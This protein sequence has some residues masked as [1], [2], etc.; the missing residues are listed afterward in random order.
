MTPPPDGSQLLSTQE[1][2]QNCQ[3]SEPLL[4]GYRWY[5]L[6]HKC[7]FCFELSIENAEMYAELP[8]KI[9]NFLLQNGRLCCKFEVPR[10]AGRAGFCVRPRAF[11]LYLPL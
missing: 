4:V 11:V 2:E 6:S 9:E 8:L 10:R 3:Y 5:E 1:N 7:H